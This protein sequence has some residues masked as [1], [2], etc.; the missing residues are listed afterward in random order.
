MGLNPSRAFWGALSRALKHGHKFFR[1]PLA[2]LPIRATIEPTDRKAGRRPDPELAERDM[3]LGGLVEQA[4]ACGH[5]Y[6]AAVANIA[7]ECRLSFQTVRNAY[8]KYLN[9]NR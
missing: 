8:S 1:N 6:E 7:S 2:G 4:I 3:A 9:S 5:G